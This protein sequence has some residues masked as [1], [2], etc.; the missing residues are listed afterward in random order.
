M[1]ALS[2]QLARWRGTVALVAILVLVAG[3][4]QTSQGHAIM[5]RFGLFQQP[6][7]YTSLAFQHP[8]SLPEQLSPATDVDVSFVIR[9]AGDSPRDYKWSVVL[10]QGQTTLRLAS[11]VV[12]IASRGERTVARSVKVSCTRGQARIV[13]SLARPAESIDSWMACT[14]QKSRTPAQQKGHGVR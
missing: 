4:A 9:N 14:P 6:A 3:V 7:S 13:V 1:S 10:T 11:G 5:A 8:Q 12:N 2:H